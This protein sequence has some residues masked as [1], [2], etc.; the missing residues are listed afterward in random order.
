MNA[1][2]NGALNQINVS[3]RAFTH[4]GKSMTKD[5]VYKVLKYAQSKGYDSTG[6]LS[7]EE[8]DAV[9][10]LSTPKEPETVQGNDGEKGVCQCVRFYGTDKDN[11]CVKC[12]KKC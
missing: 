1:D 9:L 8:V 3:W 6:Q 4:R 2:V 7:D 11:N 5:E 10:G 12:H